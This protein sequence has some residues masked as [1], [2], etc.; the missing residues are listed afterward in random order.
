MGGKAGGKVKF[1]S[2]LL[3][4]LFATLPVSPADGS[5]RV[6]SKVSIEIWP[7]KGVFG[8][9][10]SAKRGCETNR[11]VRL[12]RKQGRKLVLAGSDRTS[13]TT[14]GFIW[15]VK[16]GRATAGTLVARA[17]PKPGCR[18]SVARRKVSPRLGEY[19]ICPARFSEICHIP[20]IKIEDK[21]SLV[22]P[23]CK[24]W[25]ELTYASHCVV[26]VTQGPVP[27]CCW[28]WGAANWNDREDGRYFEIK[29]IETG[30][31]APSTNYEPTFAGWLP[32]RNSARYNVTEST[33][34]PWTEFPNA[35]WFTPENPMAAPGTPGGPIY[36][37]WDAGAL[38]TFSLYMGGYLYRKE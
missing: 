10:E 31:K 24:V 18:P 25:S 8:F 26:K 4:A 2:I 36:F 34:P 38:G 7:R 33:L 11:L 27:Y 17:T 32:N 12:F 28:A 37:N 35:K 22:Q 30:A 6:S 1:L 20:Q 3:V 16:D 13:R 15:I 21:V 9:V 29:A 5:G 19:P 14:N 23:D